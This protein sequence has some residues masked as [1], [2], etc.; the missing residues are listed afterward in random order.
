MS[1]NDD[2][3]EYLRTVHPVVDVDTDG[4]DSDIVE[5]PGLVL[6]F[7]VSV[8]LFGR[9]SVSLP[10]RCRTR[11]F[12]PRLHCPPPSALTPRKV[13]EAVVSHRVRLDAVLSANVGVQ[14]TLDSYGSHP[15][16]ATSAVLKQLEEQS[17]A[18]QEYNEPQGNAFKAPTAEDVRTRIRERRTAIGLLETENSKEAGKQDKE[19]LAKLDAVNAELAEIRG[20]K[21]PDGPPKS[22]QAVIDWLKDQLATATAKQAE[23]LRAIEAADAKDQNTGARD[24]LKM[25]LK[26]QDDIIQLRVNAATGVRKLASGA[27]GTEMTKVEVA[28]ESARARSEL[29]KRDLQADLQLAKREVAAARRKSKS[30]TA[31]KRRAEVEEPPGGYKDESGAACA[32]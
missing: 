5:I 1:D 11:R 12:A 24:A 32:S 7:S 2:D 27:E 15:L 22:A 6:R 25:R 30:G 14:H 26:L 29:L 4:Y 8:S 13:F 21:P 31:A 16:T 17:Q 23:M 9:H 10:P 3:V 18:Q 20:T 28:Y 19:L